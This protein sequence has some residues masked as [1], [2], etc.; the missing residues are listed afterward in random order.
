MGHPITEV[1]TLL[2]PKA[3]AIK[4]V[5][6]VEPWQIRRSN[7][8]QAFYC[9]VLE[10]CLWLQIVGR[11]PILVERDD[12]VM[13]STE[14]E[15]VACSPEPP[16][17]SLQSQATWLADAE[18][19]LGDTTSTPSL[20]MLIGHAEFDSPDADL[21]VS[22]LPDMVHIRGESRLAVF[23]RLVREETLAGR[24]ARELV[25]SRLLEVLLVEAFR[26]T[27]DA[28]PSPGL[29][30]GLA[31]PQVALALRAL[32]GESTRPWTVSDLAR[33]S[34]M[35]RSAFFERFRSTVGRTPMQ[36]LTTWRMAV[37]KD[38]L[39]HE[40]LNVSEVAERVGY[41]SASA[42]STAFTRH[43]GTPPSAFARQPAA[44]PPAI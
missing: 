42:F 36:Y 44:G 14:S 25:I 12:F 7:E 2:A 38:L 43:V 35:S 15:V 26:S 23:A 21:L 1:V 16:D 40:A 19:R 10:G 29:L 6:A 24:P 33:V 37:A 17:A 9:V 4:L 11:P 8:V 41:G 34:G 13:I 30:Q 22:L 32:H 20:R 5:S 31:D 28:T 39:R 27:E 3:G 18:L